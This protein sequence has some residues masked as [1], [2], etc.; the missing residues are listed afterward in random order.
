M[1]QQK[2]TPALCAVT[3]LHLCICCRYHIW[4]FVFRG[5]GSK[6]RHWVYHRLRYLHRVTAIPCQTTTA[7]AAAV[8]ARVHAA[9]VPTRLVPYLWF[10]PQVNPKYHDYFQV[11][12]KSSSSVSDYVDSLR[13]T[14]PPVGTQLSTAG[15]RSSSIHNQHH[16][17]DANVSHKRASIQN[18]A[19]RP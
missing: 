12:N 5:R 19:L 13:K 9:T 2:S 3:P 6:V 16:P 1:H 7:V 15:A 18:T 8:L 10:V 17:Q 11:R 4:L 14:N